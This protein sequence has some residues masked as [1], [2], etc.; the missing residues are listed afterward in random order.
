MILRLLRALV[1]ALVVAL[2]CILLGRVL[3]NIA[4]GPVSTIGTFLA[5]FAW[6]IGFLAGAWDFVTGG[7]WGARQA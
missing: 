7:G 5:E 2:V 6:I 1:I 3:A 4:G